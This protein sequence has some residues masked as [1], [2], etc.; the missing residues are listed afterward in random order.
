MDLKAL[1]DASD[2]ILVFESEKLKERQ[3][4]EQKK[5]ESEAYLEKIRQEVK[6]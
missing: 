1:L 5:S 4:E 3:R 2:Y 6:E